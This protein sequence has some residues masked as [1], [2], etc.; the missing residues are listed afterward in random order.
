MHKPNPYSVEE[1]EEFVDGECQESDFV[2]EE[3]EHKGVEDEDPSQGFVD[4]GTPPIYDDDV[5]EEE[6]IEEPLAS[7]LEDKY[8]DYV[9]YK[10]NILASARIVCSKVCACA[11]LNPQGVVFAKINYL[12]KL[13][14]S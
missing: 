14:L 6:P 7:N 13:G 10:F 2:D 4:W 3:F 9:V 8:E 11:R 12:S 1:E 5:N